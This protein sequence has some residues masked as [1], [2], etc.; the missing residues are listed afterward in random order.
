MAFVSVAAHAAKVPAI[1]A[2]LHVGGEEHGT[3]AFLRHL[4][5]ALEM[6]ASDA[7]LPLLIAACVERAVAEIRGTV[8]QT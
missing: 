7:P 4:V 1:H 6:A 2:A 5:A 3:A 8:S